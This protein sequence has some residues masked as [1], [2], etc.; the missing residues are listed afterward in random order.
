LESRRQAV[1]RGLV[2]IQKNNDLWNR[3]LNKDRAFFTSQRYQKWPERPTGNTDGWI[4]TTWNQLEPFNSSC[5]I[6]PTTGRRSSLSSAA[7]SLAQVIHYFRYLGNA[8]FAPADGYT[9]LSGISID[10]DNQTADFPVL[11]L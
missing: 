2:D 11:L 7:I 10:G 1:G 9:T 5:P 6:D 3:Y 8:S 4:S